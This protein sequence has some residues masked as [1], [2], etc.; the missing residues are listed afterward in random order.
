MF[1]S[2]KLWRLWIF[3]I[4]ALIIQT[5][6]GFG[7]SG[8]GGMRGQVT[9]PSGAAVPAVAV[10]IVGSNGAAR[11]VQTN[12]EGRYVFENLASGTYSLR[13]QVKGFAD[14]NEAGIVV[15]AGQVRVVD[16][17]LVVALEKQQVTVTD[18]AAQVSVSSENN[19]SALVLKGKDLDALSDDPDELQSQLQALAGPAAGPNGGEIYIDGF[20]GGQLPLKSAIREIRVN[21]NPF[22]AE[23]DKL[24]YGRI[25]ILTKPG[26]DKFHGQGFAIFNSSALNSRNPFASY[27]PGYHHEL[28]NG[29]LGGPLSSKASFFLD[30]GYRS[31]GVNSIVSAVVL[32]SNLQQTSFSQA[33]PGPHTNSNFSS[34]VDYQLSSKNTLTARYQ[35]WRDD[36][37]NNGIGQFALASQ[38][39][40]SGRNED[41][42]QI[43]NSH[44]FSERT[45]NDLRFEFVRDRTSQVP[46]S[47]D[48]TIQVIGAFTGGGS[49]QGKA[50]DTQDHYEVHDLTSISLGKHYLTFGGRLRDIN[51]WD[52]SSGNFNGSFTFPSLAAYQSAEMSLLACQTAGQSGC[53]ASGASQFSITSG[54]PVAS[55]NWIDLGLYAEDQWRLRRNMSLNLGLR[56]ETQNSIHDR[57]DVAPRLGFAW[58]LGHGATAKTV[59]RAGFGIFYDRFDEAQVIQAERLNGVNQE[60]YLVTNPDFFPTIPSLSQLQQLAANQSAP[61]VYQIAPNLRAPYTIQSAAGLER[62][63]LKTTTVSVTYLNSHGVHQFM[64]RNINAPLPG[65]YVFCYPGES[66]CTPSAGVRP[67]GDVGNIY[68]YESNG[69]FNQNQITSNFNVRLGA[70]FSLFGFYSLSFA[71][72]N[73][74]GIGSFPSDQY[75]IALDYGRAAYDVRHRLFLGGSFSLPKG[76]RLSPFMMTSSGTP[77][78]ITVGQDLNGDSLFNERPAFAPAGATGSNIIATKWGTFDTDPKSGEK[79]I[80]I[81]YGTGPG[82][83]ELNLRLSKAFAFG[84]RRERSTSAASQQGPPPGGG[85]GGPP[86]GGGGLGPRGLGGGGGGPGGPGGPFGS[87]A[88]NTRYSLTFSVGARNVFNLVNLGTPVGQLTSPMFGQSNSLA[89]FFANGGNRHVDFQVMFSF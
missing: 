6:A 41:T 36:S 62:Q 56:Y 82:F 30:G 18:N 32:G 28:L 12:E 29:S 5:A 77:F 46:Q 81:N 24:G 88:T 59:L 43:S 40:N 61:T 54:N 3:V 60:Q 23:Y 42:L 34:R 20:T 51:V 14:F 17:Q 73:T 7:E 72:S 26:Q 78:N 84:G 58:G 52:S 89:G 45:V 47:L 38:G 49:S 44:V 79:I 68:Q 22:S 50:L 64:T 35:F 63:L 39:F 13:I 80:P 71:E 76:F 67:F 27:E 4:L 19:A 9:D 25:E 53:E 66:S 31:I 87:T 83:F 70:K 11:Q 57:S 8:T 37:D 85:R 1:D 69:L 10:T 65:T 21:Q 16:A 86:P 33:I 15:T 55:V 2:C 48:P 74:A 75:D